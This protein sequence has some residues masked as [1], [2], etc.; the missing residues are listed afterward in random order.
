MNARTPRGRSINNTLECFIDFHG[1]STPKR[2]ELCGSSASSTIIGV[3]E[4]S[5]FKFLDITL[6]KLY[7]IVRW[8]NG[9]R[10]NSGKETVKDISYFYIFGVMNFIIYD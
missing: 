7:T 1:I 3:R 6:D 2:K 10:T 9:N 5:S 4:L 8:A